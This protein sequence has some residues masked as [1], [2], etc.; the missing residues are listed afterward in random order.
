MVA[1][2]TGDSARASAQL[3]HSEGTTVAG[4]H[5][6]DESGYMRSAVDNADVLESLAPAEV[7]T[8]LE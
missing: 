2:V 6:I 8:K 7:G 3:G 5:Y 1:G 4:R